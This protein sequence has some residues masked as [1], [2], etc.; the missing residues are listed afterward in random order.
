MPSAVVTKLICRSQARNVQIT[1]RVSA[2]IDEVYDI[3]YAVIVWYREVTDQIAH[4]IFALMFGCD[5]NSTLEVFPELEFEQLCFVEYNAVISRKIK[6]L[7]ITTAVGTSVTAKLEF[8]CPV[9][10][11]QKSCL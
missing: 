1:H 6:Q 11:S 8:D 7:L 9:A 2:C 5:R 3:A 10:H 4:H